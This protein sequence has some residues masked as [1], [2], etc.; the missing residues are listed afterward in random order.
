[1]ALALLSTQ[2]SKLLHNTIL[3]CGTI[4]WSPLNNSMSKL[5][6]GPSPSLFFI[7][8]ISLPT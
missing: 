5:K 7:D 1:M 3:T 8:S 4:Q 2:K 6:L